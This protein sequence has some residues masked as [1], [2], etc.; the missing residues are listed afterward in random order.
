MYVAYWNLRERPF[1]NI[2]DIR[3]AY[4]SEQQREGLARLIYVVE[5]RK[6]GGVLAGPYGVGKTMIL[7]MLAEKIRERTHTTLIQMDAPPSNTMALARQILL[8]LGST[9]PVCDTTQAL[10]GIQEHLV[11]TTP[12][13]HLVI[14][15]DE[16][17][18]LRDQETFEF[19]HL[20]CNMRVRRRDGGLGDSGI[21]LIL[22]GHQNL[23]Q[24]LA[25][26]TSLSQRLQF[27]WQ[28]EP[29]DERQTMEYIQHRMR[30][31][32]G[33]VWTFE[34]ASLTDV[35]NCTRGLPRLI[36]NLC[37]VAL[38]IG[39]ASGADRITPDIVRQAAH[40]TRAPFAQAAHEPETAS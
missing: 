23:T 15:I 40:E 31:A 33:D 34:E 19:L 20:L 3:F 39:C 14:V 10:N 30:S 22:S 8:K 9:T 12:P 2:A 26:D 21:T 6:L 27:F 4:L 1:Q 13:P 5:E 36:N 11:D 29:L 7:E 17:Q 16:A 35:F 28:L 38:L 37:D 32:G 25:A 24:Q 18:L